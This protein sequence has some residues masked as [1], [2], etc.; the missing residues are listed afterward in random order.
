MS[1]F[2]QDHEQLVEAM[3][4]VVEPFILDALKGN[5]KHP[6][7]TTLTGSNTFN[8]YTRACTVLREKPDREL[9]NEYIP[10]MDGLS[11]M[12]GYLLNIVNDSS[13]RDAE[14]KIELHHNEAKEG[15]DNCLSAEYYFKAAIE[16][17]DLSDDEYGSNKNRMFV[18]DEGQLVFF[19]KG[20]REPTAL[21]FAPLSLNGIS[22]PAGTLFNIDKTPYGY[23][24]KI[25][26]KTFIHSLEDVTSIA[27]I[28]SALY[29]LP[30]AE[31]LPAATHTDL[32]NSAGT[33]YTEQHVSPTEPLEELKKNLPSQ[34]ELTELVAE[35]P[36]PAEYNTSVWVPKVASAI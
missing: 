9:S 23:G 26:P 3:E 35:L 29:A 6:S 15:A 7:I 1:E 11:T 18:D 19:K 12:G 2:I 24:K 17:S 16:R 10:Q 14:E 25:A 28:R 30:A 4:G 32:Y 21:S 31:Q 20:Y 5:S 27:P 34:E 8:A 13:F 22:Y 33:E 36:K